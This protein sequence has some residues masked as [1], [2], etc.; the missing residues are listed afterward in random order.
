MMLD[1]WYLNPLYNMATV[2]FD[3]RAIAW[4]L[5]FAVP[6]FCVALL[7]SR[8][9]SQAARTGAVLVVAALALQ[10]ALGIATLLLRVPV[11]LA[12]LHQAGAVV[13]FA[14]ALNVAHALRM[15]PGEAR[16]AAAR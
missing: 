15:P 9:V 5:A 2:Q 14:A 1:P 12:A 3:H 6:A 4:L 11:P 13:L 7:R 16:A 10:V 8:A